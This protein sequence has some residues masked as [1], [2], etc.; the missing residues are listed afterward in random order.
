MDSNVWTDVQWTKIQWMI[1]AMGLQP[2]YLVASNSVPANTVSPPPP[3]VTPM[4][5][6]CYVH[7]SCGIPVTSIK[8]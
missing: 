5:S 1:D 7:A 2:W 6:S 4:H 3:A 8:M